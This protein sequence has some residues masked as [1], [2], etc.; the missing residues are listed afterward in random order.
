MITLIGHGYIGRE[1][2]QNLTNKFHW[3]SHKDLIPSDTKVIINAAGFTGSPNVDACENL[4]QETIDGNVIFPLKLE[5]SNKSIPIIHISSGCVYTGYKE[6]GWSETD[7]P[8]FDFNNGSF[9]SGSKALAQELLTPYLNKSYLLRIRMP[10]GNKRHQKNF[11]TKLERYEKLVDFENSLSYINDIV[12]VSIFFANNLPE[13]GIYNV[14]N[15]GSTTTKAVADKMNLKKT[16]FGHDEFKQHVRAPR[17]NCVLNC[18][19]LLKVM[20]IQ[21]VDSAL[22]EAINTYE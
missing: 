9:Y 22:T 3:I 14:C 19:K 16:W 2:A 4:K 17:S 20:S 11:L 12:A 18:D 8:N 1:I 13:P 15:P 5:N 7:P 6:G 21:N 10:F